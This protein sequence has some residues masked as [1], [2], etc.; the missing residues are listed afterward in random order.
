MS[1]REY[2]N[3]EGIGDFKPIGFLD[4]LA[5]H[6]QYSESITRGLKILPLFEQYLRLGYY[7]FYREDRVHFGQR[8]LQVV[9]QVLDVDLPKVEDAPDVVHIGGL[10]PA[11]A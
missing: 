7:P 4:L 9:N 6:V 8:L 3:L 1:F 10:Y 5:N 2:L 11:D